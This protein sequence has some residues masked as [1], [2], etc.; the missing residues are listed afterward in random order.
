MPSQR[1]ILE[2][3]SELT[4]PY[5]NVV[6]KLKVYLERI[7]GDK[8]KELAQQ[9]VDLL[10]QRNQLLQD[11]SVET[12]RLGEVKDPGEPAFLRFR[13]LLTELLTPVTAAATQLERDPE[14]GQPLLEALDAVWNALDEFDKKILPTDEELQQ[15]RTEIAD[16]VKA[17]H[18]QIAALG[19]KL[20]ANHARRLKHLLHWW[21]VT[22]TEDAGSPMVPLEVENLQVFGAGLLADML[23]ATEKKARGR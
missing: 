18:E 8:Y 1:Q 10:D 7:D 14:Q 22:E 9:E 5:G 15:R 6:F 3:V 23:V 2:S 12:A 4:F 20:K 21:D 19:D 17:I 16:S 13:N 11:I